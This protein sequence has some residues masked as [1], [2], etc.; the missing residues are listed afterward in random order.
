MSTQLQFNLAA[1]EQHKQSGMVAA[2][3]SKADLLEYAVELAERIAR[4]TGDVTADDVNAL[5]IAQGR[6][7]LGNAAGSL[8]RGKQWQ[9]T[10][11]WR[12]STRVSNHARQ[13]RVWRLK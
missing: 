1:A 5:L 7:S 10:G 13:N 2:A 6:G 4:S 11:Q 3:L 9:F 12:T 8:F